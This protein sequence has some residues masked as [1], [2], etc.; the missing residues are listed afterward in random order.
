MVTCQYCGGS[1]PL[2]LPAGKQVLSA[3]DFATDDTPGWRTTKYAQTTSGGS[4]PR[5]VAALTEHT[6]RQMYTV[7]KS[8]GVYDDLD[9]SVTIR[10]IEGVGG[11]EKAFGMRAGLS[12]RLQGNGQHCY[13]CDITEDGW[14]GVHTISETPEKPN[15]FTSLVKRARFSGL[16]QGWGVDNRMRVIASGDRI[17]VFLNDQ[18][19]ASLRDDRHAMG[20]IELLVNPAGGPARV[21]FSD[22]LI[23]DP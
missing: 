2:P 5:L 14:F 1:Q 20:R 6:N 23:A 17:R 18:L 4:P 16:S 19:A 12:L 3:L 13:I 10:F 7:L 8:E 9:L 11:T 15:A 21:A 22:L